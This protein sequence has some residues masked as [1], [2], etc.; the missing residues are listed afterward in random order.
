MRTSTNSIVVIMVAMFSSIL[1]LAAPLPGGHKTAGIIYGRFAYTTQG[2][3]GA[4]VYI[5]TL[6]QSRRLRQIDEDAY[7]RAHEPGV[8]ERNAAAIEANVRDSLSDLVTTLPHTGATKTD[9]NGF[10]RFKNLPQGKRY[11]VLAVQVA[12]DGLFLAAG[13]TPVLNQKVRFDLRIDSPWQNRFDLR[14]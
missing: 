4:H 12:E 13:T 2:Y 8:D 3:S 10:Y 1:T 11:Y 14:Q 7:A 5:F 9:S 6:T